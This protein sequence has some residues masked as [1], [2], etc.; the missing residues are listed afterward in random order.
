MSPEQAIT[1]LVSSL[2]REGDGKVRFQLIRT[3]E[4]LVRRHTS[5]PLDRAPLQE[6]VTATTARAY[7]YIDARLVLTRAAARAPERKTPGHDL[8]STLLRDKARNARGRLFRL[9][10]LLY[11]TDDFGHIYRGLGGGRELRAT[12]MEL[13]ESILGEPL[14]SAVLG[15]ADDGEDAIRLARAGRYHRP[16]GADYDSVLTILATGDSDSVRDVT[17]FHAAELGLSLRASQDEAA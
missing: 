1:D 15:L 4:R 17:Y 7:L 13:I 11:P 12:S 2:P 16:L 9:L 8:L 3:L 14:R 5:F 10:G 6:A